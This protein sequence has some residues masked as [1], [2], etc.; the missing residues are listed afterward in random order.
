MRLHSMCNVWHLSV[1][2][3]WWWL[4][5]FISFFCYCVALSLTP[6]PSIFCYCVAFWTS[7][8]GAP[9]WGVASNGLAG[10]GCQ[11]PF[12]PCCIR[13]ASMLDRCLGAMSCGLTRCIGRKHGLNFGWY[14]HHLR[15]PCQIRSR[16]TVLNR[17]HARWE[18]WWSWTIA[19][20]H[21][22]I[23]SWWRFLA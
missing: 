13:A 17:T 16:K 22:R 4:H 10:F 2:L 5:V 19:E 11:H 20:P 8:S 15:K 6:G 12:Q 14:Q 3:M 7:H 18:Q 21:S 1:T 23:H 9:F